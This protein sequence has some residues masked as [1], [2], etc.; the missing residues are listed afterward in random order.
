MRWLQLGPPRESQGALP[1]RLPRR[2]RSDRSDNFVVGWYLG[3]TG[4]GEEGKTGLQ[5][6][7]GSRTNVIHFLRSPLRMCNL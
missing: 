2:K 1:D 3:K 6:R 4:V 5:Y 7:D